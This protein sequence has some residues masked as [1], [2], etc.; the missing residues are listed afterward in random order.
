MN[1]DIVIQFALFAFVAA[2]TPGPNNVILTATGAQFGVMRSLPLLS[3]IL[4]GFAAMSF[5]IAFSLGGLTSEID[6][7]Q[8]PIRF[9]GMALLLWL[10]WKTATAPVQQADN[11][12]FK[13]EHGRQKATAAPMGVLAGALFQWVNPKAW[14][15]AAA[16]TST[17]ADPKAD[18]FAQA[19]GFAL[20]IFLAGI[21][22]ASP[23]LVLGSILRR[24]LQK[25][26]LARVFNITMAVLLLASMVPLIFA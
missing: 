2:V 8:G 5:V 15:I 3:G 6:A 12:N 17:F 13:S 7:L 24:W 18:P 25:P 21:L 26:A 16:A 4:C 9:V 11:D 1:P 14:M 10:S 20:M 23:W 22:G 19:I